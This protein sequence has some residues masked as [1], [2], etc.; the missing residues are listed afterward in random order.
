[1][2]NAGENEIVSAIR[3][4]KDDDEDAPLVVRLRIKGSPARLKE[5][6]RQLENWV[7]SV[8]RDDSV[9]HATDDCAEAGAMI[10]FYPIRDER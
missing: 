4:A 5:L 7:E 8:Q 3:T 1:M 10:A 2:L 9:D 6:Q